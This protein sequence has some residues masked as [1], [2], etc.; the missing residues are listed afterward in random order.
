MVH[1]KGNGSSSYRS[2]GV[3]RA[4]PPNRATPA[5]KRILFKSVSH[6]GRPVTGQRIIANARGANFT[7]VWDYGRSMCVVNFPPGL[8]Y[9]APYISYQQ[10][11]LI[12]NST[13]PLRTF[14]NF[15]RAYR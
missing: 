7:A 8:G 3:P 11:Q 1:A 9:D 6:A 4:Q 13:H 12:R 14:N 10:F 15:F 2:P 5:G